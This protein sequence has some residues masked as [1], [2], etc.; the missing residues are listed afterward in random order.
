[1]SKLNISP[2]AAGFRSSNKLN[3]NFEA[4]ATAIENTLSRDGSGPNQMNDV[5]DMNSER[6]INLATPIDPNDAV[7]LTDVED[8]IDLAVDIG[9]ITAAVDAAEAARDIAIAA[10]VNKL[11]RDGDNASAGLLEA[12]GEQTPGLTAGTPASGDL[13]GFF[14]GAGEYLKTTM[15]DVAEYVLASVA[16][17]GFISFPTKS[18]I[19]LVSL[20]ASIK[21]VATNSYASAGDCGGAKYVR[22]SLATLISGGYPASAFIRSV[23]RFMPDGSTDATN[24][25]YWL[26]N[27]PFFYP[28]MFGAV[29]DDVAIDTTPWRDMVATL[30]EGG[31]VR[32]RVGGRYRI[33][34][35]IVLDKPMSFYGGG[36]GTYDGAL[37][38]FI[39]QITPGKNVFTLKA[40]L[41]NYLYGQ[42]ALVGCL[43]DSVSFLGAEGGGIQPP[44]D[45]AAAAI[46]TDTTV[47]GGEYHLRENDLRNCVIQNFTR[48]LDLEGIVYLW[49]FYSVKWRFC[50]EA[51]TFAQGAS[52]HVGGQLRFFGCS[53]TQCDDFILSVFMDTMGGSL[54]LFGCTISESLGGVKINEELTLVMSGCEVESH[55]DGG[56]GVGLYIPIT[57]P[58]NPNSSAPKIIT[59][60]KFLTNDV[61]IWVDKT[62]SAFS[63]GTFAWPM[64]MDA[65]YFSAP[66]ALRITVPGGHAGIIS[67]QFVLGLSNAGTNNGQVA[68]SQIS[69][70]FGGVDQRKINYAN[71]RV[72]SN[73]YPVVYS[74][75]AGTSQV[76]STA[77][78]PNGSTL[79][80][81]DVERYSMNATTNVRG[82]CSLDAVDSTGT[83]VIAAFGNGYV[84]S[85]T[86]LNSTGSSQ[87]I[88]LTTGDG[89]SGN[90][91]YARLMVRVG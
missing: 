62:T 59:G 87:E 49:D 18:S 19:G 61:D 69:A 1:M 48:P 38:T 15:A 8:A 57:D 53:G 45:R 44:G 39:R 25:G 79:Y 46:G 27:E 24:G 88:R 12:V 70:N 47:N 9:D 77:T 78:V 41:E 4:I 21:Q 81:E 26:I 91:Y 32:F 51:L 84:P 42:Y 52:S 85:L 36:S 35:E 89:G 7:R 80:L 33:D 56:D 23:D 55:I 13:L 37:G 10:T 86:W 71:V 17:S 67:Q 60:C 65:N 63:G 2:L 75:A 20:R 58:V 31:V 54:S 74:G 22:T 72:S 3:E 50:T 28:E 34:D 6:I 16:S 76:L 11:D 5:I 68:D 40:R 64:T 90:P 29:G 82:S 73:G 83:P 30:P 14:R 66:E 43:W